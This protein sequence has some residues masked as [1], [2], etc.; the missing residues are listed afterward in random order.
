MLLASCRSRVKYPE[1]LNTWWP[2]LTC[3][4]LLF[5]FFLLLLP[6]LLLLRSN[7]RWSLTGCSSGRWW[8]GSRCTSCAAPS[9]WRRVRGRGASPPT[10]RPTPPSQTWAT[11]WAGPAS[12]CSQWWGS[13]CSML[14]HRFNF[15]GF[16]YFYHIMVYIYIYIYSFIYL[17]S[18]SLYI[19]I[20][21]YIL[22]VC[23]YIYNYLFFHLNMHTLSNEV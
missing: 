21:I 10:C 15:Y 13:S 11:C 3:V 8:A 19:Y 20:Y 22:Y 1:A 6:L 17:I 16:T 7:M 4:L 18:L 9:S 2:W 5:F 23:I 12:P 14:V